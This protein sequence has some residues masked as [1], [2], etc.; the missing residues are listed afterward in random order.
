MEKRI[1]EDNGRENQAEYVEIK[2]Q[3]ANIFTKY[4]PTNTFEYLRQKFGMTP[5][6]KGQ[7]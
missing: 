4:L 1:N 2:E 3:I 7:V 6:P 5:F